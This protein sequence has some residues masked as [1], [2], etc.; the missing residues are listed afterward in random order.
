MSIF[1][2]IILIFVIGLI[3]YI[4]IKY[5]YFTNKINNQNNNI[6]QEVDVTNIVQE[7]IRP[8]TESTGTGTAELSIKMRTLN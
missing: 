6:P 8:I 1:P 7:N 4:Y 5:F 3:L 2:K